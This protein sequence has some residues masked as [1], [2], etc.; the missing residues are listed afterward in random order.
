MLR[1]TL[2]GANIN[3]YTLHKMIGGGSMGA[4]Y[5]ATHPRFPGPLAIK[6]LSVLDEEDPEFIGRFEREAKFLKS[7]NHPNIVPLL[8]F[9]QCANLRYFVMP[10]VRGPS[11]DS[12]L[13]R[14][15]FSPS[16]ARQIVDPITRALSYVH[17]RRIVHR[18]IKPANVLVEA[19][20]GPEPKV[21]LLDFG[22]SKYLVGGLTGDMSTN[23]GQPLT[24]S[25]FTVGTPHYMSPE[26]VYGMLID[27]RADLYSLGVMLYQL[28]LGVLP[29]DHENAQIVALRQVE[30][31]PPPPRSINS[32]FPK[33]IQTM[34]LR[35]LA[36][37][38]EDRYQSADD[39][40]EAYHSALNAIPEAARRTCYWPHPPG[41]KGQ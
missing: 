21:Y 36:K 15:S 6:V 16:I 24:G 4:I 29:F 27:H 18:D 19:S 7:L 8:D 37:S 20:S 31:P 39:L 12:L 2:I 1:E 9:G 14:R 10:L 41:G 38:P 33:P 25:N 40:R 3:D 5:Q 13:S 35:A 22:L 34:L 23:I 26:Q 30:E 11:V 32:N 17:A 28:L